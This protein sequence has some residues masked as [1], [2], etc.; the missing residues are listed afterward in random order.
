MIQ[1][2]TEKYIADIASAHVTAW[3]KAFRGIL[4]D[5]QLENLKVKDFIDG[6]K[7][8]ISKPGR[9][10]L[11]WVTED[12]QAVGFVAF[13]E[14]DDEHTESRAEIYG[15]YVHP[16]YWKKGIG[17]KLMLDAVSKQESS[18]GV[19]LWV[20]TKNE[21]SRKFYQRFGFVPTNETRV[22]SRNGDQFEEVKYQYGKRIS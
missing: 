16:D 18:N 7:Q 11:I 8:N 22:S 10:N 20:M 15:I 17:Y 21:A 9:T 6:W 4:S 3:Q 19:F 12:D 5:E 14:P 13:G 2:L 1:T